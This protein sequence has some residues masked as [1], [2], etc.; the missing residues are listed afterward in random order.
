[1]K[2]RPTLIFREPGGRDDVSSTSS[3]RA[4][5]CVTV[6][7]TT[8]EGTTSALN[9][10]RRLARDLD[11]HI[12]LLKIEVVVPLRFPFDKPLVSFDFTIKQQCSLV[13][14]SSAREDD[15][16]I[17]TCLCR[18]QSAC[19]R[20]ALRRRALVV[21]GGSRHWWMSRQERLERALQQLG[22][23]VIFV[24]V[25]H[26]S[27]WSSQSNFPLSIRRRYRPVSYSSGC[28]GIFSP[29]QGPAMKLFQRIRGPRADNFK[30]QCTKKMEKKLLIQTI[31]VCESKF[32]S[33]PLCAVDAH[34]SN[35]QCGSS[36]PKDGVHEA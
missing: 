35:L 16:T 2:K 5:L 20:S 7:A 25:N 23:H 14:R 10:A 34:N 26:K 19:L 4:R 27:D 17:R 31:D 28:R 33:M 32:Q 12:T 21:I 11:A 15:V 30:Q 1:M 36:L 6:I 3:S 18:D 29:E 24:D 22:H 8:A 13:L 9:E